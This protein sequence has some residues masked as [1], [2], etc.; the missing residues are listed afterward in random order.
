MCT[1]RSTPSAS[2]STAARAG[3]AFVVSPVPQPRSRTCSD[4]LTP[5]AVVGRSEWARTASLWCCSWTVQSSP[6]SPSQAAAISTFAISD[7][8]SPRGARYRAGGEQARRPA[9]HHQPQGT[10]RLPRA[11][12]VGMRDHAGRPEVKSVREGRAN[13]QDSYT[14]GRGRRGLALRHARVAVLVL[15]HGPR[16][17]AQTPSCCSTAKRSPR[18]TRYRGERPHAR[19]APR[20]L[21]GRSRQ[22]RASRSPGASA[23]TTSARPSPTRRQARSRTG[24]EGRPRVAASYGRRYA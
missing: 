6:S 10:T 15:A 7:T 13:L 19:P 1:P 17:G 5:A 3:F 16:S 21:Q 9:G 20:V 11:R 18:S 4:A 12:Y 22:G 24:D 14:A 8:G 23:P 2:P